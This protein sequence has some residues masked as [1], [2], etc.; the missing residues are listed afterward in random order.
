MTNQLAYLRQK[1]REI[2]KE[3]RNV[4]AQLMD[5]FGQ[6]DELGYNEDLELIEDDIVMYNNEIKAL[7]NK[8][9]S[10]LDTDV[11]L[12]SDFNEEQH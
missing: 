10:I 8:L 5:A 7:K 2:K 9:G 12:A 11:G 6:N 1:L 3:K 4:E